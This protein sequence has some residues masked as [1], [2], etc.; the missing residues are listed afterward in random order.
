MRE[1]AIDKLIFLSS[2]GTVYGNPLYTPIDEN[3]PTQPRSSYGIVKL[4]IE[5]YCYLY[6]E[7]HDMKTVVLRLSNPYGPGQ[8]GTGIQGAVPVFTHKALSG[9]PIE[10]WGDG[11]VIRDYIHIDD[12]SAAIISAI[13]Y[14]GTETVFN[15]GSGLGTSINEIIVA[16]EQSLEQKVKV[17]YLPAR[18]LDV[19][20]SVLN[21]A[22]AAKELEWT[23]K[24]LFESGIQTVVEDQRLAFQ[25]R[26]DPAN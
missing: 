12:V 4:A 19:S 3:H 13:E 1:L 18:A 10:V 8:L 23:P 26:S 21:I 6:N 16:I 25:A 7:L 2:G 9:E 17:N 20:V 11:S 14:Q 5:K 24:V 22:K 15:I